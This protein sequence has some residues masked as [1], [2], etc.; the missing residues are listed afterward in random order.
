MKNKIVF[1]ILLILTISSCCLYEYL[2]YRDVWPKILYFAW[3]LYSFL[4]SLY[5]SASPQK[6]EAQIILC[7][8]FAAVLPM[9]ASTVQINYLEYSR[10]TGNLIDDKNN[11]YDVYL[12]GKFN[13]AKVVFYSII[14]PW[15]VGFLSLKKVQYKEISSMEIR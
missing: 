2:P 15:F 3:L 7:C 8:V 11:A 6:Q 4:Y 1:L 5:N 13:W 14:F 12:F 10:Y 9:I